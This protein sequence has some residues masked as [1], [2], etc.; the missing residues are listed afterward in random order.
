MRVTYDQ[1][2][3][4]LVTT[5]TRH[6]AAIL[7]VLVLLT[8]PC[9]FAEQQEPWQFAV[10][11]YV[12]LPSIDATLGFH[13][14]GSGGSADMSNVLTYLSG[15]FFLNAEASKGKW[16]ASFDLVYC[17]FTKAD[18]KVTNVV[19]PGRGNEVPINAGT[20]TGLT[21]YMFSLMG[22]Y[23]VQRTARTRFDL[24]AGV[25][26]THIG[27]TLDWSFT[28]P[29]DGLPSRAGSAETGVDLWNGVVGVRGNITLGSSRWYVPLYLDGGTG[30]SRFTWQA[31][32][33]MG[34]AFSWGDILLVY[35]H[36]SFEQG[37]NEDLQRLSFSGPALGATFRF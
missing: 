36:L 16:G 13:T 14:G 31:L 21:G 18:S 10:T 23:A 15:A 4:N 35:R 9:A 7:A 34:Y 37:S 25:R 28:N 6:S 20:T 8:G 17:D 2:S 12:W 32:G 24:L 19:V 3:T 1:E 27:A 26:Y 29:V 11:P 30:T 22:S 5:E 33:G